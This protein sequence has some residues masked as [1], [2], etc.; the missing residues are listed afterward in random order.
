[1]PRALAALTLLATLAASPPQPAAGQLAP[2]RPPF[3]FKDDRGDVATAH[4]RGDTAVTVIIAAMPG[5]TGQLAKIIEG[6]GG[7]I[8]FRD[9]Q[10][11]YIRA[12]I[13]V[14]SVE[15]LAHDP[16]VHSLNITMKGA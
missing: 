13:P 8:R 2:P 5:A 10:V 3:L 12:R 1:M 4:A 6:M 7:S 15:H 9:D 11:D 14:D 16:S